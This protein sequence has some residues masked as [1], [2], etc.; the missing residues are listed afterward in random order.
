MLFFGSLAAIVDGFFEVVVVPICWVQ[1]SCHQNNFCLVVANGPGKLTVSLWL[2]R[3][4]SPAQ[5]K[6]LSASHSVRIINSARVRINGIAY[7]ACWLKPSY[8]FGFNY[9]TSSNWMNS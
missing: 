9:N 1:D 6:T 3:Q 4:V 7:V 5:P 2:Q 8:L